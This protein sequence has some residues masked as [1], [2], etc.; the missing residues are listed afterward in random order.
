MPDGCSMRPW[1]SSILR[2]NSAMRPPLAR[3]RK[4]FSGP[5]RRVRRRSIL[6]S[7]DDDL[8]ICDDYF[9]FTDE[10]GVEV[11]IGDHRALR[12]EFRYGLEEACNT[13]DIE[14]L[15]P[16]HPQQDF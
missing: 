9:V 14:L 13:F 7:A 10:H 15:L 2:R 5:K 1:N 16:A 3:Q 12:Y 4:F 6:K 11:D 8:R